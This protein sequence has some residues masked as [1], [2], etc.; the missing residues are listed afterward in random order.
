M[1]RPTVAGFV[2]LLAFAAC[3][4]GPQLGHVT[5]LL[6]DAPN[7]GIASA[8][9]WVSRVYLVGGGAPV[10]I[11][12]TRAQYGLLSLQGGATAALGSALPPVGDYEQLRLEVDS[13]RIT[14]A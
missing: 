8:T 5:W 10:D 4:E 13:A 3:N 2:A 11:S 12:T 7:P 9:V 1:T 6:T 14:L